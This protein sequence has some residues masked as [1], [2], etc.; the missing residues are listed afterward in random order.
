MASVTREC[1]TA[2]VASVAAFEGKL[3]AEESLEL[4]EKAFESARA[5][6][7]SAQEVKQ[8]VQ[9]LDGCVSLQ[10][11]LCFCSGALCFTR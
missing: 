10:S 9:W 6:A 2:E 11:V 8:S 3:A 4:A 5:R 1:I 7:A